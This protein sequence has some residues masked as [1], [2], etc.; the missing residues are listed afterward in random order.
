MNQFFAVVASDIANWITSGSQL[1][2]RNEKIEIDK[3]NGVPNRYTEYLD[4]ILK[5]ARRAAPTLRFSRKK[6][7][8]MILGDGCGYFSVLK[9]CYSK[10]VFKGRLVVVPWDTHGSTGKI[11]H[12]YGLAVA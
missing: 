9:N 12:N 4:L 10:K 2:V 11:Y 7:K 6:I 5:T 1:M 8:K 3:T